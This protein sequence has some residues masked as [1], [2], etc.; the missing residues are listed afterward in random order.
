M[1]VLITI[2]TETLAAYQVQ[3]VLTQRIRS[4]FALPLQNQMIQTE[5]PEL[6]S[7]YQ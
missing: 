2:W 4:V 1:S 6:Q 7:Q 3:L 5:N